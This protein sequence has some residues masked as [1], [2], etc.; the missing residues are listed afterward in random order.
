MAMAFSFSF[1]FPRISV[2]MA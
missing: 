1:L 2:L